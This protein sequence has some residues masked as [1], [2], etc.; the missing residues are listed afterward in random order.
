M[1]LFLLQHADALS[2]ESDP[3]RPLSEK[4]RAQAKK[5]GDFLKKL[6]GYPA[7]ILHSGKKRAAETAEIISF[8]LGGIRMEPREYLGPDD[9]LEGVLDELSK[10]DVNIMVVGHMPFL[11]KLASLLLGFNEDTVVVDF[12]NASPLILDR[13][14]HGY[15]LDTY[16]KN[17][18][19]K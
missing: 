2:S 15:R 17:E 7:I 10:S 16:V 1:K 8:A 13:G 6:P 12:H 14:E 9:E 4:G 18:Y 5:A 3:A 19:L 11:R